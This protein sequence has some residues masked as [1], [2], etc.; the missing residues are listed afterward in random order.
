MLDFGSRNKA[1]LRQG[2]IKE[3]KD[4]WAVLGGRRRGVRLVFDKSSK[5]FRTRYDYTKKVVYVGTDVLPLPSSMCLL[6]HSQLSILAC[7]AHELA[8]AERHRMGIDRPFIGV[9]A[10]IE[11]AEA[12]LHAAFYPALSEEDR[13][14]LYK[15]AQ[16]ILSEVLTC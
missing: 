12:C 6:P 13:N 3:C 4:T 11:E 16:H 5:K 15:C 1:P 10:L 8:H 2:H 14:T 9:G 7:L